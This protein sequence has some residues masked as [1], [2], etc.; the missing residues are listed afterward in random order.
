MNFPSVRP[1]DP[2]LTAARVFSGWAGVTA[3]AA[4][5]APIET[6][7]DAPDVAPSRVISSPRLLAQL[8]GAGRIGGVGGRATTSG[9]AGVRIAQPRLKVK[10][11]VAPSA[12]SE[13]AASAPRH[14]ARDVAERSDARTP[15]SH[16]RQDARVSSSAKR[17]V[18]GRAGVASSLHAP[19]APA[20]SPAIGSA[21][22]VTTGE[23]PPAS[24]SGVDEL[25]AEENPSNEAETSPDAPPHSDA[26]PDEG[27]PEGPGG[28][29]D[30]PAGEPD[31]A[32]DSGATTDVPMDGAM[33]SPDVMGDGEE[34]APAGTPDDLGMFIPGDEPGSGEEWI[35]PED[36]PSGD[37][38]S[39][40]PIDEAPP[41]AGAPGGSG[42][43]GVVPDDA[44]EI[45]LGVDDS[46]QPSASDDSSGAEGASEPDGGVTPDVPA[47]EP[48]GSDPAGAGDAGGN[49]GNEEGQPQHVDVMA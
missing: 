48:E 1:T 17:A 25:A 20:A 41:G 30:Q 16:Q 40:A 19:S 33:G 46:M 9:V 26:S 31:D 42:D 22:S 32:S 18:A 36:A 28:S 15:T 21:P 6:G 4:V 43:D 3:R 5:S 27:A 47:T 2:G 8:G 38:S 24:M 39:G 44:G 34:S 10:E 23:E 7:G 13:K 29:W 37:E 11:R 49:E 12:P 35:A 14:E 45:G